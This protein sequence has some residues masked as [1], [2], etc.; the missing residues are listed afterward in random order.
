[1]YK[2]NAKLNRLSLLLSFFVLSVW[3]CGWKL[4]KGTQALK[5]YSISESKRLGVFVKSYL[6]THVCIADSIEFV[7]TEAW[8]ER[9]FYNDEL[10]EDG[11]LR[12]YRKTERPISFGL[13]FITDRPI[14]EVYLG[15]S[16]YW[17]IEYCGPQV[18]EYKH[19]V[20]CREITN[21][22]PHLILPD[23]LNLKVFRNVYSKTQIFDT[24]VEFGT[25]TL[26][27][28]TLDR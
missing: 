22:D 2:K 1:M 10:L 17:Y 21:Y 28:D 16:D 15:Y 7:I 13:R 20:C 9:I 3:S 5:T 26:Y 24:T 6:P 8:C 14:S 12:P 27:R 23:T 11:T 25:I 4:E 19:V 18:F